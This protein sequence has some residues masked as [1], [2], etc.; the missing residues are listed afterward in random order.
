[1][2]PGNSA[3]E[4]EEKQ[5]YRFHHL[6]GFFFGL[7]LEDFGTGSESLEPFKLGAIP[8]SSTSTSS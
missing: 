6:L 2:T 1:M 8:A 5:T 7:G 3:Q 4:E